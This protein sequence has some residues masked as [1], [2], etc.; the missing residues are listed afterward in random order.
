V[1]GE[2]PKGSQAAGCRI[3][4]PE[5]A[6]WAS[7][8]HEAGSGIISDDLGLFWLAKCEDI[9]EVGISLT[10]VWWAGKIKRERR[11]KF[12]RAWSP[13]YRKTTLK[14][15]PRLPDDLVAFLR[16]I[17]MPGTRERTF[18]DPGKG[19]EPRCLLTKFERTKPFDDHRVSVCSSK[20]PNFL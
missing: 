9:S 13:S 12:R 18:E 14:L 6:A 10:V 8:T 3:Q 19:S 7:G 16:Q 11:R 2:S 15:F 20:G 5:A 4:V 17:Q 1:L